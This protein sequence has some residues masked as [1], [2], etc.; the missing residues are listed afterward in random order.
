MLA[1]FVSGFFISPAHKPVAVPE[2]FSANRAIVARRKAN[3]FA[4]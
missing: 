1:D 4:K 3:L 2:K